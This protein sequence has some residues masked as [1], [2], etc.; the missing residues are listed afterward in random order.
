LIPGVS[1]PTPLI[2]DAEGRTIDLVTGKLIT[3]EQRGPTLKA[4]IRA[5]RREDFKAVQDKVADE[6]RDEQPDFYDPRVTNKMPARSRR[7]LFK[8]HE[9]GT[10]VKMGQMIRAKVGK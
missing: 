4:N 1:K 6:I 9:K 8:F 10:F 7:T 5:K 3:L 2:L